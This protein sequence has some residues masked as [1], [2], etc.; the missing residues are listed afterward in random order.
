MDRHAHLSILRICNFVLG[1]LAL[2]LALLFLIAWCIPGLLA[3]LHGQ[4]IG[5]LFLVGGLVC[6]A[7]SGGLGSL[8]FQAAV[9]SVRGK[10]RVLQTVLA[11]VHLINLPVGTAFAVYT[12]W[13]CWF[14][15]P[16]K[17]FFDVHDDR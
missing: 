5:W 10:R 8:H 4:S 1:A 3:I 7:L 17:V 9:G 6:G 13:V 2:G 12:L 15:Q 11:L 16:T 14:H